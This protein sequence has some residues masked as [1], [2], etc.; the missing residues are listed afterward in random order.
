MAW[1]GAK[2]LSESNFV[3]TFVILSVGG[4]FILLAY[5]F[6]RFYIMRSRPA[7]L[8]TESG[9]PAIEV[10]K[11]MQDLVKEA[12]AALANSSVLEERGIPVRVTSGPLYLLIGGV[13]SGKSE[14]FKAAALDPEP[15]AGR[16]GASTSEPSTGDPAVIWFARDSLFVELAGR[17]FEE[18]GASLVAL[19]RA[20]RGK[21]LASFTP[22][23]V[24]PGRNLSGVVLFVNI[25]AVVAADDQSLRDM[26][27]RIQ[28][29]LR[30]IGA[31]FGVQFPVYV[32]FTNADKIEGF[33][34]YFESL[35]DL[36]FRQILGCTLPLD[37]GHERLHEPY[38]D[39]EEK[40]LNTAL[41]RMTES[42]S[43]KLVAF[44]SRQPREE[45]R[46]AAFLYPVGL[47]Q[48][49]PRIVTLLIEAFPIQSLHLG[50]RLRGFYFTGQ[51]AEKQGAFVSGI[52][53]QVILRDRK[54]LP[55]VS[56]PQQRRAW[57]FAYST[58]AVLA[59]MLAAVWSRSWAGNREMVRSMS[60][61]LR[62]DPEVSS[63]RILRGAIDEL[64]RTREEGVL[65][66]LHWGLYSGAFLEKELRARYFELFRKLL[67]DPLIGSLNAEFRGAIRPGNDDTHRLYNELKAYQMMHAAGCPV[68]SADDEAF[69]AEQMTMIWRREGHDGSVQL[70]E[71]SEAFRFYASERR[72]HDPYDGM[73]RV[74]EA[75]LTRVRAVLTADYGPAETYNAIADE[76]TGSWAHARLADI[77]PGFYA[78]YR[79][80]LT[81]PGPVAALYTVSKQEVAMRRLHNWQRLTNSQACVVGDSLQAHRS[82]A[83]ASSLEAIHF[84]AYADR[85]K[86]F[87][88]TVQY[89]D[90]T[91]RLTPKQLARLLSTLG[92]NDSPVLG[93][94]YFISKETAATAFGAAPYSLMFEPVRAVVPP[95][96]SDNWVIPVT[97]P[98]LDSLTALAEAVNALDGHVAD[99]DLQAKAFALRTTADKSVM[100]IIRSFPSRDTEGVSR[101]VERLLRVPICLVDGLVKAP[102]TPTQKADRALKAFHDR[103]DPLSRLYPFQKDSK[104]NATVKQVVDVFAPAGGELGRLRSALGAISSDKSVESFLQAM[105]SVSKQLFPNNSATMHLVYTLTIISST[106]SPAAIEQNGAKITFVR[107]DEPKS[108]TFLLPLPEGREHWDIIATSG[109]GSIDVPGPWSIYRLLDRWRATPCVAGG[110][111]LCVSVNIGRE[112]ASQTGALRHSGPPVPVSMVRLSVDGLP[113]LGRFGGIPLRCPARITPGTIK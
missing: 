54:Q 109:M 3:Q 110:P 106:N 52:F 94:L 29:V 82:E 14:A 11:V 86:H 36:D 10:D 69:L 64:R 19:L 33:N 27:A 41:D 37:G 95:D 2:H 24:Q 45:A 104:Q 40:R 111:S 68:I 49:R 26:H 35:E 43:D 9:S 17:L 63:L 92:S 79:E 105:E 32:I 59:L 89:V 88:Q 34:E 107:G 48:I 47:N 58:C 84:R 50:P 108:R 101:E 73:L 13:G 72:R 38:R 39:A 4:I 103:W 80:V 51:R 21:R 23:R 96:H 98:Y 113:L 100:E 83:M 81:D 20:L 22:W 42:I 77:G 53:H 65:S 46:R 8:P 16:S 60:A 1:F 55:P 28:A 70:A 5:L 30:Q 74:D 6:L 71:P 75:A 87:L 31:A 93:V 102:L 15:I 97:K 78:R 7:R 67:L 91:H 44:L 66:S 18:S 12:D 25:S 99:D 61:T 57:R 62:A 112:L 85:W 90:A 76:L 56:R